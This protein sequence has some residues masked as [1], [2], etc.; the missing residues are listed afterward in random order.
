MAG[1]SFAIA[2]DD[3]SFL[4]FKKWGY[5]F[6]GAFSHPEYLK[7]QSGVYVIWCRSGAI[8]TVLDVGESENIRHYV[9]NHP[10]GEMWE[11]LCLNSSRIL[12]Y[13]ATYTRSTDKT[14]R[15][16]IVNKI[17]EAS[18]PLFNDC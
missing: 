7:E 10:H 12:Y 16:E 11:K 8:W 18:S 2:I 3:E 1:N 17:K 4:S 14:G 6:E 13:S 5:D 9:L 15:V